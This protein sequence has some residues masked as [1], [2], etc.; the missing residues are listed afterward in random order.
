M[1]GIPSYKRRILVT[2][3]KGN[4]IEHNVFWIRKNNTTLGCV[5]VY[6]TF[7][8]LLNQGVSFFLIQIKLRSG[9]YFLILADNRLIEQR[10]EKTIKGKFYDFRRN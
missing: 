8:K 9:K 5:N 4:I 6:A 2:A 10:N 3:S 7:Q 1:F